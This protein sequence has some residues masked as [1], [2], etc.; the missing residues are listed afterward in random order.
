M[1]P[2]RRQFLEIAAAAGV[3]AMAPWRRAYAYYNSPGTPIK[4]QNWPGMAKYATNLRG[5][6]PSGIPVAI[7]DG[8][9][10]TGATHYSLKVTEFTDQL[11][12]SIG[13]TRLWGYSP[14]HALG[15]GAYPT[16]HLGGI[17]VAQKGTPV[18]LT[19]TNGLPPDHIL[20]VDVSVPV[21]GGFPDAIGRFG[22]AGLNAVSTHLHGG[23]VPWTSDGGPMAWFTPNGASAPK[24]HA[25]VH[26][27]DQPR[28]P[29]RTG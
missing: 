15:E 5:V 19:F 3:A 2:S 17:V 11:H 27:D 22:G 1:K 21:L 4:G 10:A 25:G 12:P 20:P 14:S 28:A 24:L 16:R 13:R 6:G 23:F 18:Q 9:S 29:G 7:P 26:E 8:I